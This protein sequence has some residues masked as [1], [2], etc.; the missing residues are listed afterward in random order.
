MY[1]EISLILLS[2]SVFIIA[3][4]AAP[5]LFQMQKIIKALARTQEILQQSLPGILSNLEEAII[6]IKQTTATVNEQIDGIALSVGKVRS[7]VDLVADLENILHLGLRLP[8]FNF[9]RTA[10]AV[11]KGVRTFLNVYMSGS[12][13]R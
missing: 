8:L 10:N 2:A 7:V 1:L 9:F 13:R 5:L 3:A 12:G 6:N 4:V 11:G